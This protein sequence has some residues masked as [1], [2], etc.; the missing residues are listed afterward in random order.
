MD[1]NHFGY[2]EKFI[3]KKHSYTLILQLRS[4]LNLLNQTGQYRLMVG[5]TKFTNSYDYNLVLNCLMQINDSF[6]ASAAAAIIVISI[7]R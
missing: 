2:N 4:Y 6:L 7:I 3:K 1:N 5:C